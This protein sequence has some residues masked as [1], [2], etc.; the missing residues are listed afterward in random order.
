LQ[1]GFAVGA[2]ESNCSAHA[3]DWVHDEANFL[4]VV[5]GCGFFGYHVYALY[6]LY[7]LVI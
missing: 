7:V 6:L 2:F 3:C 1:D 4:F 5:W